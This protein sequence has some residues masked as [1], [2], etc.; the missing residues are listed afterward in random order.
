MGARNRIL[1]VGK[2]P[3]MS[4]LLCDILT[5]ERAGDRVETAASAREALRQI[6]S[7]HVDAVI[8]DGPIWGRDDLE[9]IERAQTFHEGLL[10]VLIT[11]ADQDEIM[12]R[13]RDSMAA[14]TAFTKPF[15]IDLLLGTL[16]RAL[17][18]K[19]TPAARRQ[20][21]CV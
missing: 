21:A 2:D 8:V 14:F 10:V 13:R 3:V 6:G 20:E 19:A 4:N 17:S 12:E 9:F 1:V 18:C 7:D 16:D 15:S 11:S 5:E